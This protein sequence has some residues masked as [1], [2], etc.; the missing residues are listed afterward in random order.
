MQDLMPP[1]GTP[2]NVFHDGDPTIGQPG[3][4]VTS[5]WCNNAQGAIRDVQLEIKNVLAKAGIQ[6]DP[7][8]NNQLA[9]AISQIIG[10]GN[11]VSKVYVDN[12]LNK[13]IDKANISGVKGNDNDKVPSL[14]LLTTEVGKLQPKGEYATKTELTN[15]L[16]SK[17]NN[18]NVVQG[19]GAS[20]TNVMSQDAVTKALQNAVSINT[21]YPVGIVTWFAQNKNPNTLFPGTKWQ[22][23][24]ENKTI[25]LANADGVNVLTTGGS[26][27][28]TL[29]KGHLP[30]ISVSFSGTT[31]SSG[32]HVHN[33]GTMNIT[34][35]ANPFGVETDNASS[36]ISGAFYKAGAT[37]RAGFGHTGGLMYPQMTFD[38]SR[39]WVGETSNSGA[40]VHT[41][42]GTTEKLGSGT[43]I[44][45]TNAYVMLMAWYR[46]S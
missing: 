4:I 39:S 7:K 17:L 14:N 46:I 37:A 8:K 41:C 13:K 2:D 33:R 25:R 27:T 29:G 36:V 28:V 22:Y 20:T 12:E 26:D 16:N 5:Q 45:V 19:T 38:A 32:G 34:G 42:T 11:Y 21:I 1:I 24:G 35:V 23:I 30:A 6:P 44:N 18:N 40:H 15:G 10:S 31:S 9:E 3:T 43:A